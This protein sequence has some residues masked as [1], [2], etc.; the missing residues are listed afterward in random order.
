MPKPKTK[1]IPKISKPKISKPKIKKVKTLKHEKPKNP[2]NLKT[3]I[4]M[5]IFS[6]QNYH[7]K[8][9]QI[10]RLVAV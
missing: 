3:K 1:P 4:S 6:P 7:V 10:Y 5:V 2:E 9:L 8:T